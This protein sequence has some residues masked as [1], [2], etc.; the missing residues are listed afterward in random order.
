MQCVFCNTT[1]YSILKKKKKVFSENAAMRR[2]PY[3]N[4]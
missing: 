1:F 2:D 4:V 3:R